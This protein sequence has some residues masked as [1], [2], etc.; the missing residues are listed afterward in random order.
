M[1]A[2][3]AGAVS[4]HRLL[5]E[6]WYLPVDDE[7]VGDLRLRVAEGSAPLVHRGRGGRRHAACQDQKKKR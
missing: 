3:V 7:V 2:S 1:P 5:S 4:D 6:P